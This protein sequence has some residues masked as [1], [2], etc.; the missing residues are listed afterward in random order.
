MRTRDMN[1]VIASLAAAACS[2]FVVTQV[3]A[4][5]LSWSSRLSASDLRCVDNLI[6]SSNFFKVS[7]EERRELEESA[8]VARADLS[9]DRQKEYVFLFDNIGWCGSAGCTLLIGEREPG[10]GCRLLFSGG[11]WYSV[12]VLPQRDHGYHRLYLPCEVRFDGK[13]Y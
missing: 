2:L 9:K 3:Q 11:G 10:G 6:D 5:R 8:R 7:I 1:K 13:E 4:A 12:R